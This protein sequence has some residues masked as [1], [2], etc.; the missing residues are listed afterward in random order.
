MN[1]FIAV[2]VPLSDI[3]PAADAVGRHLGQKMFQHPL[4]TGLLLIPVPEEDVPCAEL[5]PETNLRSIAAELRNG[6]NAVSVKSI[7]VVRIKDGE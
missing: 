1:A 7:R 5:I 4:K 2:E 6:P 3:S